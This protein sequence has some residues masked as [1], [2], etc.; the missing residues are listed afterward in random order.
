MNEI[1]MNDKLEH[2]I[3]SITNKDIKIDMLEKE[4][5]LSSNIG[6]SPL[7]LLDL[8]FAIEREFNIKIDRKEIVEHRLDK[9]LDIKK[10]ILNKC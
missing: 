5:L 6:L 8:F 3:K 7:D 1:E 9:I 4:S 2:I 10:I